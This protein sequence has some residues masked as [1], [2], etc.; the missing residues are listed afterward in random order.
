MT[1][2]VIGGGRSYNPDEHKA[3]SAHEAHSSQYHRPTVVLSHCFKVSSVFVLLGIQGKKDACNGAKEA[4]PPKKPE[5]DATANDGIEQAMVSLTVV[6]SVNC[7][8]ANYGRFLIDHYDVS[9]T[10][11][12][13]RGRV[14]GGLRLV[15][16]G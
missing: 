11:L 3:E 6:T 12:L 13:R 9:G 2:L 5:H 1:E 14:S 10:L 4:R 8:S 7:S 15:R 16:W